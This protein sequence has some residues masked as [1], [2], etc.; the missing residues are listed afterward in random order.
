MRF[1]R[2]RGTRDFS[3]DEM[4]RRREVESKMR[5]TLER[6]G[7]REIMTPTLE[8]LELFLAKSGDQIKEE[9][10]SFE[11]RSRRKLALRPEITASVIR[12]YVSE[13]ES[14]PKPLKLY[15]FGN[16]FRYDRPQ[17]SRYREFFQIG[18]E[19]IGCDSP[20]GMA[21]LIAL[22]FALLRETGM[23]N[24][25]L[26]IGHLS[27]LN[28]VLDIFEVP[29]GERKRIFRLVDKQDFE[30]FFRLS[31]NI[32]LKRS[33]AEKLVRFLK[34]GKYNSSQIMNEFS[35]EL[36]R[37]EKEE[38]DKAQRAI[39]ELEE[40]TNLVEY[41]GVEKWKIHLGIARG[42]D[43]YNGIVFET[44]APILG[45]EKQLC[46]GGSYSLIDLLGGKE[47]SQGGFAIGFDR[48]LDA[49]SAERW[50]PGE[51]KY[52]DYFVIPL[53]RDFLQE[54]VR[55]TSMLRQK[56]K[57]VELEL[58][59]RKIGKALERANLIGAKKAILI[60]E[61]EKI[62]GCVT[63]RDM[64]SGVQTTVKMEEFS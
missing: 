48:V 46:G 40:I 27:L 19:L 21:E 43:Y 39:K 2:V 20:E 58:G 13:L 16:C 63:V 35:L 56:S 3:P 22:S 4:S 57:K 30:G 36:D 51:E 31:E 6:W 50:K 55:I 45:S 33:D 1:K 44:D 7:Y 38:R 54:G 61:K 42:L 25:D 59:G 15:Y 14:E 52:V 12:F 29:A 5:D 26:R 23:K 62:S 11:D 34:P 24:V 10:Y 41:F 18:C 17:R 49:L 8:P 60:G 32:G 64:K 9:I 47:V 53:G 28:T 37:L